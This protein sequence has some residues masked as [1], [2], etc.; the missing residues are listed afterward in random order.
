MTKKERK[1]AKKAK[2][3]SEMAK[4]VSQF[5]IDFVSKVLHPNDIESEDIEIE[6]QLVDDPDINLNRFY[7]KGTSNTREI[8]NDFVKKERRG[9]KEETHVAPEELEGLLQLLNI[10]PITAA[11]SAE[12]KAIITDLRKKIT[13]DLLHVQNE[14]E[15]M[16][17]RKGGFWR[18]ASKKAYRRLLQNGKIWGEKGGDSMVAKSDDTGASSSD[19]AVAGADT[20]LTEPDTDAITPSEDDL[21][22]PISKLQI[23]RTLSPIHTPRTATASSDGWTTVGK[24]GKARPAIGN[25]KLSHNGGLSKLAQTPTTKSPGFFSRAL[26]TDSEL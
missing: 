20:E 16:M 4:V 15:L 18:W 6:R 21:V 2:K 7:H 3:V 5:D 23:R 22:T 19:S 12:E 25:L 24:P 17:M 8:R 26:G 10:S 1:A 11:T 9:N 14:K 13:D